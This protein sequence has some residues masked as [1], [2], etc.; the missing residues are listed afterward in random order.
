MASSAG[1]YDIATAKERLTAAKRQASLAKSMLDAA[2]KEVK[3]AEKCLS[4][5]EKRW[6]VIDIDQ[7][8]DTPANGS[9]EKKKRKVSQSPPQASNNSAAGNSSTG[10][11]SVGQ[12]NNTIA[13]S[14]TT[15]SDA[16]NEIIVTGCVPSEANGTYK[17]DGVRN[18]K[19]TFMKKER[20]QGRTEKFV[21]FYDL[22]GSW[23]VGIPAF[24]R[25]FI[26]T[27]EQNL[28]GFQQ[29]MVKNSFVV[30]V[31]N[32]IGMYVAIRR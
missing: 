11:S 8:P 18:G 2:E 13:A 20:W 22:N 29:S 19:P 17:R 5:A 31:H 26:R 6:E 10:R 24:Q 1:K 4:D 12:A 32:V 25:G 27:S 15:S 21:L 16:V 7:E 23:V 14:N 30:D 9:R 3:A 28:A